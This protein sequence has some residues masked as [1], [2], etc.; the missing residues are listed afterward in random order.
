MDN[1]EK[2]KFVSRLASWAG[3]KLSRGEKIVGVVIIHSKWGRGIIENVEKN[4]QKD[5]VSI[6][7]R[8]DNEVNTLSSG[9]TTLIKLAPESFRESI[10]DFLVISSDVCYEIELY[11]IERAE[12]ELKAKRAEEKNRLQELENKVAKR[13]KQFLADLKLPNYGSYKNVKAKSRETHCYKCKRHLISKIM[14]QCKKCRWMICNCGA[15]GCGY[16]K[17]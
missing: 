16:R 13:H 15:C 17:Y 12:N 11:A 2:Y 6:Y 4:I 3:K 1:F 9:L 7:I 8:L 14:L 10:I 5:E